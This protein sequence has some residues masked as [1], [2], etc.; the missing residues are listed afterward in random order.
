MSKQPESSGS[1]LP[2]HGYVA[3]SP[4][5]HSNDPCPDQVAVPKLETLA[6]KL[7]RPSAATNVPKS[8]RDSDL[9]NRTGGP[10]HSVANPFRELFGPVPVDV[11]SLHAALRR[12]E[13]D[14]D[15]TQLDSFG[16]Q[17]QRKLFPVSSFLISIVA[18]LALFLILAL[19]AFS[20]KKPDLKI[21]ILASIE[22]VSIPER[23]DDVNAET[24]EI[25]L[26]DESLSPVEMAFSETSTEEQLTLADSNDVIPNVVTEDV[27][28]A[29][30][31]LENS[32]VPIA[33]LPAGGG[34]EGRELSAR[35]RLAA[36]RGGSR[37]SEM[38]VERGLQWILAH[39]REDGSWH[40][41][42]DA[43]Q[44]NGECRNQGTQESTTAATGLALMSFLGAG[45]THRTGPYQ[46]AVQKG[47]DYLRRKIRVSKNG[48]SLIQGEAGMYSH[49]IATIA[50]SEAYILTRDTDLIRPLK[51]A[52]Q[53]IETAQ[54][55][56]GGWRYIPGSKG[57]MT[58]TGWQLMALKS[59]ELS[60]FETGEITWSK[61]ED[62]IN[63]VGS[64]SGRYGYQKPDDKNPTTTAVGIL[65]KMYL[66]ASLESLDLGTEFIVRT[67]PSK[68]DIYFDYYATQVLHHRRDANW[69]AWN[70]E[71]RDYLINTQEVG[72]THRAGSW[73]FPDQHGLVGGRLYTTAMAVMTLEVYYR[74]MPLY[75]KKAIR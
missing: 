9:L 36:S 66:G 30:N 16:E 65:S 20:L 75:D 56:Q 15:E 32:S 1:S 47:L 74:Y 25:Q 33:T 24:V 23:P 17:L 70:Q 69:P 22:A 10:V 57:D 60:G 63:S 67:G 29:P 49:A 37:A 35:A 52:R 14:D 31:Q 6:P 50:L 34:L 18:H 61:A 5:P 48:G 40:F 11:E 43:G 62:F 7:R 8:K 38:A 72:N 19:T 4:I 73:Y 46:E 3:A 39:Q 13:Q 2:R 58:V 45:Y 51:L 53:Y 55:S 41:Y 68:T 28:P 12:N 42:H 26:P 64:S 27:S 21:N 71:M 59:C 54:H 44:C